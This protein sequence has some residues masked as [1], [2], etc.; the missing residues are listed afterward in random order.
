MLCLFGAATVSYAQT[1]PYKIT[2]MKALLF[3]ED[4]GTFSTDGAEDDHGPPYVPPK[5]WNT[6]LQYENRSTSV[7][8][9]VEVTG[10]AGRTPP[11]SLEFTARYI[12]WDRESRPLVIRKSVPI[13]IPMKIE[14]KDKFYAGFWLYRTGCNPV[15]LTARVVGRGE[16][17][18]VKKVIK[19]G[20][21]E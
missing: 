18:L 9:V 10:D 17:S 7:F 13:S 3:Y 11:G 20:C 16:T 1:L 4:K 2:S 19:F 8:V 5:F 15:R 21:G 12:P 6:P 14:E